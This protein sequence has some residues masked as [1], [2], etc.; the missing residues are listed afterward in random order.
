MLTATA[1]VKELTALLRDARAQSDELFGVIEDSSMYDRPI[2][3]RHRVIFYV[4][5]LDGF[6][7]IQIC[8][9]GLGLPSPN[10]AF[11]KLFQ[12]GIDPDSQHL[13]ADT[14]DDWPSRDQ[15]REYV[16]VCREHVDSNIARAPSPVVEMALEHRWMHLETLAYMFHNFGYSVKRKPAGYVTQTDAERAENTWCYVP[17]GQAFLGKHEDGAFGWDNEYDLHQVSVAPFQVQRYPVTNG[18]YL[19][20]VHKTGATAPHFWEREGNAFYLR[21]MFQRIPLP[22]DWPAYV[23]QREAESYATWSGARLM[24]EA[25][26]H[27]AAYGS[28]APDELLYPWGNDAPDPTRGN[29]DFQRWDPLPVQSAPA[30]D[31]YCGVSQLVGNGWEWTG[32]PFHPFEGFKPRPEYPGYSANFF[33]GEHYVM[34]GGCCR[35]AAGLLRPSFRNWF[36]RDYPYMYAKFRCVKD[37]K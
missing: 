34:K 31:S 20:F 5:H 13:P 29:F 25:E 27:R 2:D 14:P 10:P 30:G 3:A 9:E 17:S 18:E 22:L 26:F 12:A 4:G 7:S 32:T 15:V 21:G 33:D 28:A 37:A 16:A 19:D 6:D 11:D 1:V 23:T 36:R 35:T 24:S 8:R